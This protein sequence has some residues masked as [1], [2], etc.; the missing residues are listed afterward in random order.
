MRS[1]SLSVISRSLVHF[2]RSK[3]NSEGGDLAALGVKTVE[4][5]E[6]W[7]YPK[8]PA[9]FERFLPQVV[10]SFEGLKKGQEILNNE[11]I[12][13]SSLWAITL[14]TRTGTDSP[15]GEGSTEAAEEIAD[16]FIQEEA[17]RPPRGLWSPRKN[18]ES[19]LFRDQFDSGAYIRECTVEEVA[20]ISPMELGA[21][22]ANQQVL[23][24]K[25][26]V[27]SNVRKIS[28]G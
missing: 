28:G 8:N 12:E 11:A 10:V 5:F 2:L 25:F 14:I 3:L 26:L 15:A 23:K 27:D 17:L 19:G 18:E 21:I 7:K 16:L 4:R 13:N 9:D 20:P 24:I 1:H 22:N 6:K